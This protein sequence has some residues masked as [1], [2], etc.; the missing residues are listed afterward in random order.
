M[1]FSYMVNVHMKE[2]SSVRIKLFGANVRGEWRED[3]HWWRCSVHSACLMAK[4]LHNGGTA[5]V[6]GSTAENV[7]HATE[8]V[9]DRGTETQA[10]R[11][12]CARGHRDTA[13]NVHHRDTGKHEYRGIAEDLLDGTGGRHRRTAA[14][15][16]GAQREA[17]GHSGQCASP[18]QRH[19]G[20]AAQRDMYRPGIGV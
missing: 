13:D 14:N 11:G 7:V 6:P 19:S 17:Q 2:L 16:L 15:V 3:H 9:L 12:E 1:R 5:D 8:N 4:V 10:H 20:T 18:R